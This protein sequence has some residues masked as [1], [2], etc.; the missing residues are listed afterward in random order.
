M[1][2]LRMADT[3]PRLDQPR[4]AMPGSQRGATVWPVV[5]VLPVLIVVLVVALEVLGLIARVV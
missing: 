2:R 5:L 4:R 1:D 3:Q